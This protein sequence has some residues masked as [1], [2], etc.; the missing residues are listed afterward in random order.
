VVPRAETP[1]HV[2]IVLAAITVV[3]LITMATPP[4]DH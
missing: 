4:R 3:I 2:A 1:A